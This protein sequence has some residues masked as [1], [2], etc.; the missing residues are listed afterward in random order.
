MLWTFEKVRYDSI[1]ELLI[2]LHL[3]KESNYLRD[4]LILRCPFVE[5]YTWTLRPSRDY[6]YFSHRLARAQSIFIKKK[7]TPSIMH[8]YMSSSNISIINISK[9]FYTSDIVVSI[10][11]AISIHAIRRGDPVTLSKFENKVESGRPNHF[12]SFFLSFSSI[13]NYIWVEIVC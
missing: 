2:C 8:Y 12:F 6:S 10:I 5:K 13:V 7:H 11:H 9:N 1:I 3:N 4:L